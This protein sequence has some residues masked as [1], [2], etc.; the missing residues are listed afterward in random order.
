MN[1]AIDGHKNRQRPRQPDR[2]R[3][4]RKGKMLWKIGVAI[5]NSL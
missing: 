2:E 1:R 5:F 4:V 3:L